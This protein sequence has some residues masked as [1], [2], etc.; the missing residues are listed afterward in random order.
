[1]LSIA[2]GVGR[3]GP[4]AAPAFTGGAAHLFRG[5]QRRPKAPIARGRPHE[6]HRKVDIE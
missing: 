4:D 5:D 1:M 2:A 6:R 3:K